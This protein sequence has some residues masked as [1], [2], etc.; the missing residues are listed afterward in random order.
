MNSLGRILLIPFSLVYGFIVHTR[1]LLYEAG[2]L[3][4]TSFSTPVISVGNLSVGGAGKTPHTEYLIRLLAPYLQIGVLSRGY[5]RKS[6]GFRLVKRTDNVTQAGDEPLQYAR[7][8]PGVVVAVSES[9]ALGIPLML[10][11]YPYLK[12][13]IL[14]DAFQHL[15]VKPAL[16][17][18]L[19]PYDDLYT[20]DYILPAGRLREG[21][22]SANRAN[23]IIVTKCPNNEQEIDQELVRKKLQIQD[24]QSLFFTD[25]VYGLPYF[26]FDPSKRVRIDD[27]DEIVLISAIANTSYLEHYMESKVNHIHNVEFEDHHLYTQKEIEDLRVL[28]DNIE[29]NNKCIITTEKDATRLELL[30]PQIQALNLPIF[31]LPIEVRFK[32]SDGEIFDQL[33]KSELLNFKY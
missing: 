26:F 27:F 15:S 9:R 17:I 1:N 22:K 6:K 11:S 7:K 19:T 20:D 5:K 29:T 10:K 13:I 23:I 14:D 33:I 2:V 24:Y 21:A 18:L 8:Y 28:F 16:N 25:Y 31:I 4:S 12:T 32:F 3:R 30:A